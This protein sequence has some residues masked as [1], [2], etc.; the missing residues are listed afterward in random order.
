VSNSEVETEKKEKNGAA[1]EIGI[2]EDN[3]NK[4]VGHR[5]PE[6]TGLAGQRPS[7]YVNKG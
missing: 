4:T 3:L 5:K 1:S 7:R 6:K 2:I